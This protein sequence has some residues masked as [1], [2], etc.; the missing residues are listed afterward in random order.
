MPQKVC[1]LFNGLLLSIIGQHQKHRF[2]SIRIM[3]KFFLYCK[4]NATY[5]FYLYSYGRIQVR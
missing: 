3:M 5:V 1:Y 2:M 4:L